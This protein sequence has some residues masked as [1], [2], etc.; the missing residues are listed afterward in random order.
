MHRPAASLRPERRTAVARTRDDPI[1]AHACGNQPHAQSGRKLGIRLATTK[2]DRRTNP[3][4]TIAII[5][6]KIYDRI[7]GRKNAR[8]A[9]VRA[10]R[11]T[12]AESR[13]AAAAAWKRPCATLE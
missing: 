2:N 8:D 3:C 13:A 10:G 7:H 11:R 9:L 6:R 5:G 12:A 1:A 4:S